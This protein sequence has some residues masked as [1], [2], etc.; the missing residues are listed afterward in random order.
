MPKII[1]LVRSQ[2]K[3]ATAHQSFNNNL[4]NI[5]SKPMNE[6]KFNFPVKLEN[7]KTE[8]FLVI[9]FNIIIF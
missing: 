1:S 5:L 2:I 3:N 9:E 8:M 4:M 7:K 6:I